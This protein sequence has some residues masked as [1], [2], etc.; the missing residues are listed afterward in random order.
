MNNDFI[1]ENCELC[2]HA[3]LYNAYPESELRCAL[4]CFVN[5][6]EVDKC[7]IGEK[8]REQKCPK[9]M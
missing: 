7:P 5:C 9:A 4:C 2:R 3:I 8:E 6:E 1:Y